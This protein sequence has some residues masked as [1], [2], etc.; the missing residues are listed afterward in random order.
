[1]TVCE[2]VTPWA[3]PETQFSSRAT[4]SVVIPTLNEALNMAAVL[5]RL[6][7]G[8]DQVILVDGGSADGTVDVARGSGR[9]SP[10]SSRRAKGKGTPWHAALPWRPATSS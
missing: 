6:P 1:M 10:W 4:V 7:F 3:Y 8:I 5:P 9:T 2:V